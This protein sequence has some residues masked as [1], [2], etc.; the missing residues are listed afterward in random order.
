MG[1]H[2]VNT[3]LKKFASLTDGKQLIISLTFVKITMAWVE[4]KYRKSNR[5]I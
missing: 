5:K 2:S 1:W 3:S 4:I